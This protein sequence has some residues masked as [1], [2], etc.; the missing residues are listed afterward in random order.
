MPTFSPLKK[1]ISRQIV[2]PSTGLIR[3]EWNLY[4]DG[5][6]KRLNAATSEFVTG[7][8]IATT[9]GSSVDFTGLP[10]EVRR[11]TVL[12]SGVSLSG[13]NDHLVQIGDSGGLETTVYTSGSQIGIGSAVTQVS[14]TS[15]FIMA[16]GNAARAI[17][18]EMTITRITGNTWVSSHSMGNSVSAALAVQGGGSKSLSGE[19]DRVRVTVTGADTYDA[20]QINILYEL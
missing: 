15:G 2:D 4:F 5:L 14:S 13:T 16:A 8:V 1:P 6:T 19:L 3:E 7:T 20:G 12:Y 9:S 11:L 18:G 10:A 17:S